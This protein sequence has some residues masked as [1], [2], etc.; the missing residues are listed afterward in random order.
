M[1]PSVRLYSTLIATSTLVS[2]SFA[3]KAGV[4]LK[5]GAL[6]SRTPT[7][8]LRTT[9]MPGL[10]GGV[11]FPWRV[12]PKMELQPEVL[13]SAMG[14]GFI[15]P[16]NDRYAIRSL[17]LQVPVSFKVFLNNTFNIH[18]GVQA[19]RLLHAQRKAGDES[20]DFTE[21]LNLME[22]GLIGGFGADL[23]K[24]LDIT[25]RYLSGMTP[26]LSNDQVLFPR[27][28]ALSVTMGYRL[29]QMQVTNK[30][31]RRR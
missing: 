13:V 19:S 5:G 1:A 23:R 20:R 9:W 29:M 30:S 21:R 24:G 14:S 6:M 3:Q 8:L 31:R 28:Q 7:E 22:Y 16:D 10:T 2:G 25:V 11:Y 26:I 18:G 12:G 15:E 17:Y 4:G 27:N